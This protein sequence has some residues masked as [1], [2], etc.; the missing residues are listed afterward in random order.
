MAERERHVVLSALKKTYPTAVH[1]WQGVNVH[2]RIGES[3]AVA[4]VNGVDE[5]AGLE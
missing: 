1:V 2:F 3:H 5:V 4:G